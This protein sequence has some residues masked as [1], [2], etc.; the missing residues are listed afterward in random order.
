MA[1]PMAKPALHSEAPLYDR[2]FPAWS[3][4]QSR[5]LKARSTARLDWD[6]LAEEIAALGRSERS[7]IRS[8]IGVI[9][10]H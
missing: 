9:L 8:R 3:D 4:E 1:A 5:L 10:I 2:D 7:G 6:N